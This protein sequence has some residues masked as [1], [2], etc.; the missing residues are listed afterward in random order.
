MSQSTEYLFRFAARAYPIKEEPRSMS[1]TRSNSAQEMIDIALLREEKGREAD[2]AWSERMADSCLQRQPVLADD[3]SYES[4]LVLKGIE[5]IWMDTGDPKYF[6]FILR[7]VEQFVQPDGSI[8]TYDLQDYNLDQINTGKVLFNLY[9]ETGD[10][11]YPKAL[12]L[13]MKQLATQ[14][15]TSEGGFWHKKIYPYQMWL[16]GIYM[17]APFYVQYADRFNEPA[18]FDDAAHQILLIERH[19]HDPQT[20]LYYHAWDES[21]MQ[22]WAHLHTG[23][24][25]HFWAR[26]LGWYAMALVD[27][28]DFLPASHRTRDRIKTIFAR[29]IHALVKFQDTETGLWYQVLDRGGCEG[30]YTESSASCM[31]VYAL[32]KGIRNDYLATNYLKAAERGYAGILKHLVEV[33]KFGQVNL[34]KICA[35]AGLGGEGQRDGSYE[36]YINE[37]VVTNDR[38][39]VGAFLLA[40]SEMERLS[41]PI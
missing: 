28:L 9:Q 29:M 14:P 34:K 13:L 36:Y 26:A 7:N 8:H 16:D 31:F 19:T 11:R 20:G 25:P 33:D 30:N 2:T 23:C 38:K 22:P 40:C 4:G 6:E 32:A 18:G 15:R 35:V 10:E 21:K 5:Q 12:Q 39:G 41:K 1:D 37:P 17:S 27:V 3:W 24:S